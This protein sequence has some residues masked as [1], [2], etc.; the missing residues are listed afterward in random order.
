MFFQVV[1]ALH[2]FLRKS[3]PSQALI[4]WS[5]G[6]AWRQLRDSRLFLHVFMKENLDVFK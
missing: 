3:N 6:A 2:P 5:D 1:L 4:G